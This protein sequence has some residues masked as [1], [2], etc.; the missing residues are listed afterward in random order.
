ML[1]WAAGPDFDRL[2]VDTV[3][4]TYPAPEHDRF[5]AHFRGLTSLWVEDESARGGESRGKA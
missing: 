5:V 4:A 1:D 2:L 3:S